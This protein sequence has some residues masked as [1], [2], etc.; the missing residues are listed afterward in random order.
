MFG[1]EGGGKGVDV[2]VGTELEGG[3]DLL[4]DGSET[5]DVNVSNDEVG[6]EA[7]LGQNGSPRVR[8]LRMCPRLLSWS[9]GQNLIEKRREKREERRDRE[10]RSRE[11]GREKQTW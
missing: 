6:I 11:E 10:K 1:G 8:D 9:D 7:G 3:W 2:N 4:T 5:I